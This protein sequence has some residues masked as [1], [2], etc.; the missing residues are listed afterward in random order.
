MPEGAINLRNDASFPGFV[1]AAPP[2][3]HG[4]HRYF[5]VVHAVDVESL[6]VGEDATPAFLGFNLF[7]HHILVHV[8]HHVDMRIP[9]YEL[10]MAAHAIAAAYPDLVREQRLSLREYWR[11]TK[12]CK[13]YDFEHGT[14]LPFP[15]RR[16]HPPA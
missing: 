3:G 5:V 10:P 2:V 12:R 4:P 11:T 9:F 1:G 16:R 8:P 15:S 6:E 13:L 7:F 14:W